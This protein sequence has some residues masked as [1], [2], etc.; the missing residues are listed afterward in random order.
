MGQTDRV[1]VEYMLADGT[2]DV[3]I[4]ELLEAKL[5][6]INTIESEEVPNAS[7]LDELMPSC[8]HLAG[9]PSGEQGVAGNRR[10]TDRLEALTKR[11]GI[12]QAMDAPLLSTA[13]TNSKLPG[14]RSKITA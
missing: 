9:T 2:L 11:R 13:C 8:A 10:D 12:P 4:A 7:V 5:R 1:T 14:K 6:L 3:F